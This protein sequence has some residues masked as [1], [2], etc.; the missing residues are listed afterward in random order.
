MALPKRFQPTL[1][2]TGTTTPTKPQKTKPCP[3]TVSLTSAR[4]FPKSFWASQT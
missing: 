1:S 4:I 3:V 2:L